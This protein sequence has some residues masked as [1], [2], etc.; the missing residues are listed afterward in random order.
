MKQ[1]SAPF[2]IS[3]TLVRNLK[4]IHFVNSPLPRSPPLKPLGPPERE[5][6]G[7]LNP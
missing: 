6:I 3:G 1:V 7:C 4:S 5:H 2:N